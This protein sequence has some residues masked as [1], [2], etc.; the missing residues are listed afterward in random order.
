MPFAVQ[1][2]F[3][4]T[5][6]YGSYSSKTSH[7]GTDFDTEFMGKATSEP[8]HPIMERISVS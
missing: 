2:S 4:Q 1:T 3:S 7:T 5:Y 6:Q 8:L